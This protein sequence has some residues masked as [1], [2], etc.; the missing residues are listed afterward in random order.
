MQVD[1]QAFEHAISKIDDGDIFE[2]FGTQFLSAE[3]GY[4]FIPQAV[5]R[6]FK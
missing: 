1:K 4:D 6:M 2:I 5:L 3:L